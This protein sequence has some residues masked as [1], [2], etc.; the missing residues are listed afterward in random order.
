M[1]RGHRL[2]FSNA[3]ILLAVLAVVLLVA[4]GGSVNALVPLFA[5]G[6]FSA[7]AMAGYGMTKHHL[8]QRG[9]AGAASWRS[10]C[11]PAS[12]RRSWC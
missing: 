7:F 4:T 10:T 11:R 2:V 1:K 5:M 3:I 12:C 6:V 9:P 8:T